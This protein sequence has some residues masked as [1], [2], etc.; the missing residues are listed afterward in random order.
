[1]GITPK[2]PQS[3]ID[4]ELKKA[5]RGLGNVIKNIMMYVGETFVNDARRSL[6]IDTG[7]FPATHRMTKS[8]MEKGKSQP[9]TGDYLDQTSNLRS[10][11]GY[12]L[13]KD[14]NLISKKLEGKPEGMSAAET[15]AAGA[16][17]KPG[18]QLIGVA[19]MDYAS[20][21]ESQGFNVISSQGALMQVNLDTRIRAFAAK[22]GLNLSEYA[23]FSTSTAMI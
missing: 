18:Y 9:Q 11:I 3:E 22:K 21:V 15:L 16:T 23:E 20:Y 2:T 6:N 4:K 10:S 8:E 5:F 13:Y 12:F 1:M 7:A 17:K 14:G 19:G